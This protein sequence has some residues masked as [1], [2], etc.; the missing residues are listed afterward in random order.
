ME[1]RERKADVYSWGDNLVLM[2]V[3]E[4]LKGTR[5]G[6]GVAMAVG[7]DRLRQVRKILRDSGWDVLSSHPFLDRP[8]FLIEAHR[9]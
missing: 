4:N 7:S 5:M 1:L 6:T 9:H 2:G 3:A 8:G